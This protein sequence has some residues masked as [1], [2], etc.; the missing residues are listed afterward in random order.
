MTA[1]YLTVLA[2]LGLAFGSFAN[3]VIWRYPRGE[4]LSVPGS[5]CPFC[6]H[7]V[8]WY[9]NI[10]VLS[11]ILLRARC[12]DCSEP[13]SI[14][15]PIVESLSAVLWV[16]AGASF[17]FT[18][19]ALAAIIM[20]YLLLIL[21]FID[22]DTMRLPNSLVTLLGILGALGALA[23]LLPV[24]DA[25]PLTLA[26]DGWLSNPLVASLVGAALGAGVSLLIALGYQGVRKQQ[27][28]GMGDVK[29]LAAMGVYLGPYVLM[30][31]FGGAILGALW[32]VVGM[33]RGGGGMRT[34]F[35]FGPFLALGG[36]LTAVWGPN[37]FVW[38][39]T[40]L[41]ITV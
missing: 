12:R 3:V 28:F 20:F 25:V 31:F 1:A 8:R 39:L 5:H 14:R 41:G 37:L 24:V 19:R 30:A 16:L 40:V 29:L 35:P 4:S 17:G 34:K 23:S 2:L 38:Y 13:I 33:V 11:W 26:T 22:L 15:Y 10:P 27:G 32:G 36:V 9:D 21:S 7:P 6:D 18:L